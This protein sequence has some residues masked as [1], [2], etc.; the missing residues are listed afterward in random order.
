MP[1]HV[2][3]FS[4]SSIPGS[5]P[6]VL[7]DEFA[8]IGH[9]R[10]ATTATALTS[11]GGTVEVSFELVDPPAISPWFANFSGVKEREYK[12]KP[13]ILNATDSL[14]LMRMAVFLDDGDDGG[15]PAVDYFV[16]NAGGSSGHAGTTKP[17]SLDL[18]PGPY[19]KTYN[20]KQFGILPCGGVTDA[21]EPSPEHYHVIFPA[22]RVKAQAAHE[23]HVFSSATQ[24][25]STK[26]A[27]VVVDWETGLH[28][29]VRH[30]ASSAV[31]AGGGGR[32]MAWID[33]WRGVLLCNVLDEDPVLRMLQWPVPPPRGEF[34]VEMYDARSI[35]EA[36]VSAAAG[37]VRFVEVSFDGG[38]GTWTA[39]A[40]KR[41][42]GSAYWFKCFEVDIADILAKDST[43]LS[44]LVS[45][46]WDDGVSR[47]GL[48]K[49]CRVAPTLSLGGD[50]VVYLMTGMWSEGGGAS[51]DEA[52]LLAVNAREERLEA[53]EEV[54]F[55]MTYTPC[56][57]PRFDDRASCETKLS[58]L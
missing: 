25:W 37:E 24:A 20:P 51:P 6:W 17:P 15:R 13:Q 46:V 48:S 29:V 23:M 5:S 4:Q 55:F 27:T 18:I 54:P 38:A 19:P 9:H 36:A 2:I 56:A 11:A 22:R 47:R 39:T 3:G 53:V 16:Y 45:N 42:V 30:A 28:D 57:F 26:L 12:R 43:R 8:T 44:S 32:W 7:L 34:I 41:E 31:P 58:M 10:N 21:D 50:D 49:V 33:L 40:W 52:L 1:A 35:R 14:I